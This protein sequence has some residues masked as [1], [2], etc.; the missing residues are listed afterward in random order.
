MDGGWQNGKKS[1]TQF[2]KHLRTN[3]LFCCQ[4]YDQCQMLNDEAQFMSPTI[5][6]RL[7]SA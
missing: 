7:L 4:L 3:C 6:A 5:A 2:I 1:L